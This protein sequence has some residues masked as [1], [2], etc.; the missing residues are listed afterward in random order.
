M[1]LRHKYEVLACLSLGCES[2]DKLAEENERL[3][4]AILDY[5]NNPA[6]FD[7]NILEKIEQLEAEV[8]SWKARYYIAKNS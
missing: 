8:D 6:G 4:K 7:W 3:K 1:T 2:Y 5:G